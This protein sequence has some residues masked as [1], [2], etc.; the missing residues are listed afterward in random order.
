MTI[1]LTSMNWIDFCNRKVSMT[2][3][4]MNRKETMQVLISHLSTK[5]TLLAKL[6]ACQ[7][8]RRTKIYSVTPG[9]KQKL[10]RRP[11]LIHFLM[12]RVI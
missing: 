3:L 1:H 12:T 6:M 8:S 10:P 2:D 7:A 9:W 11:T 5:V 4:W